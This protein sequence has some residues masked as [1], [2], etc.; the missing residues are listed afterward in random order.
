MRAW[1]EATPGCKES[2]IRLVADGNGAYTSA[3]NLVKD[4]TGSR[5]GLRSKRFAAIIENG[6]IVKLNVDE[7]GLE[8]TSA[9][10]VLAQL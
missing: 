7:K 6:E 5:L 4:A 8:T 2:G 3:L 10:H 1:L 9:E